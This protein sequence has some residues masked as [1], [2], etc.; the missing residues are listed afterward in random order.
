MRRDLH[1]AIRFAPVMDAVG[2]GLVVAGLSGFFY[3]S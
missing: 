1:S 3:F 2:A